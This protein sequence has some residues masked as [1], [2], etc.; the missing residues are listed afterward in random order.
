MNELTHIN[1]LLFVQLQGSRILTNVD[2]RITHTVHKQ[3][4]T[5]TFVKSSVLVNQ[6][7]IMAT[8]SISGLFWGQIIHFANFS[9]KAVLLT[10]LTEVA[11]PAVPMHIAVM[12]VTPLTILAILAQIDTVDAAFFSVFFVA[13]FPFIP[14]RE[15]LHHWQ[16]RKGKKAELK[17][18]KHRWRPASDS[19]FGRGHPGFYTSMRRKVQKSI[20]WGWVPIFVAVLH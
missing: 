8:E 16:A 5:Q 9:T 18:K 1:S 12:I 14:F 10:I 3:N 17:K 15:P 11:I 13:S 6:V 19:H 2:K 20:F 7:V 4:S